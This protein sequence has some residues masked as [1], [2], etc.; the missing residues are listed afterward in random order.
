MKLTFKHKFDG[1]MLSTGKIQVSFFKLKTNVINFTTITSAVYSHIKRIALAS[2]LKREM[3]K[4][5]LFIDSN[6]GADELSLRSLY[7]VQI[8]I[9]DRTE[10]HQLRFVSIP[11]ANENRF[12]AIFICIY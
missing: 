8:L 4:V 6:M 1:L 5:N 2:L 10:L 11:R 9:S 3:C 12:L 7:I